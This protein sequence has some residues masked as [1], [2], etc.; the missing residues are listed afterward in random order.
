MPL[1][2]N[3]YGIQQESSS[4]AKVVLYMNN[5]AIVYIINYSYLWKNIDASTNEH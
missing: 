3:S 5:S 4:R 1:H 2:S